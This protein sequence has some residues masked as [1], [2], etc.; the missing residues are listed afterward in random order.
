MFM[1]VNTNNIHRKKIEK[2]KGKERE[3][4]GVKA[5]AEDGAS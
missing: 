3:R 4:H 2:T 1:Y 5:R